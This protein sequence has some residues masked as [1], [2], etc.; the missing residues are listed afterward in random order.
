[1][2]ID[3][4][5]DHYLAEDTTINTDVSALKE[6]K[7]GHC[8]FARLSD[9]AIWAAYSGLLNIMLYQT[10]IIDI[11]K[12]RKGLSHCDKDLWRLRIISDTKSAMVAINLCLLHQQGG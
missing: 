12:A 8:V 7:S 5:I 10:E 4:K 11:Q 6:V 9:T 3:F 1:M 2:R